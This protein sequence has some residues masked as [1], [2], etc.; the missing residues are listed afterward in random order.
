MNFSAV[1]LS[2]VHDFGSRLSGVASCELNETDAPR[3]SVFIDSNAGVQDTAKVFEGLFKLLAVD[4]EGQVLDK[5]WEGMFGAGVAL[6]LYVFSLLNGK[7]SNLRFGLRVEF[8][9]P[10]AA[11]SVSPVFPWSPL[12]LLRCVEG[13]Q[14]V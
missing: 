1:E 4:A 3:E 13:V 6:S 5:D 11:A 8:V 7:T 12:L 9:G 2:L 14:L 10:A